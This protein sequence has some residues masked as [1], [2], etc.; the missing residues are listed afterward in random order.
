MVAARRKHGH[1]TSHYNGDLIIGLNGV[2]QGDKLSI[3]Q[4]YSPVKGR[5]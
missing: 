5:L 1:K 4:Y 3:D 2:L